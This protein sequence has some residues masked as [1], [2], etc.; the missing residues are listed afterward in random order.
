MTDL[1][2]PPPPSGFPPP[3]PP[4]PFGAPPPGYTATYGTPSPVS[5]MQ[6][7]GFW[8]R[9]AALLID[10][11]ILGLFTI[12]AVIALQTGPTELSECTVDNDGNVTFGDGVSAICEG[13]T[14]GTIAV[15]A[16][17]GLLAVAGML[18]YV[19]KLEGG[20]SGQTLGKQALGIRT[21]DAITGGPIGAGRA[22]GRYL[23]KSFISGNVCLLGYLWA[24]WD[25]R[26]QTW[27]DKV[28]TSV[29]VKA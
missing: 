1:P 3:P 22:I 9:F 5:S 8:A 21:V 15:A 28:V 13:P 7:A 17:L 12:P 23:F 19:A 26:K 6:Y 10:G 16:L 4:G 18:L 29:V 25:G 11:V 24:L 27:H 20:P 2:P 14:G